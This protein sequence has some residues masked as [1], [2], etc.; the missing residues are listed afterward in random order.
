VNAKGNNTQIS[1][2]EGKNMRLKD[3]VEK[4]LE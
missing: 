2:G 4:A 1:K 3:R